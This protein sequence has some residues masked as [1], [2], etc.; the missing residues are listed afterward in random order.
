MKIK[1]ISRK[2]IAHGLAKAAVSGIVSALFKTVFNDHLM[3][4]LDQPMQLM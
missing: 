2:A 4:L 3:P 1:K